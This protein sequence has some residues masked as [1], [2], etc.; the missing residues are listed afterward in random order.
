MDLE[1]VSCSGYGK[2]GALSVLQVMG[3]L[4]VHVHVCLSIVLLLVLSLTTQSSLTLNGLHYKDPFL[5][6][7]GVNIFL[8]II[9]AKH[10]KD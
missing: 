8:L 3:L 2:N 7:F 4:H 6:T 9:K 1:L 5:V 10:L